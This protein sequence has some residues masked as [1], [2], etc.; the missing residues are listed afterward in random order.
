[1]P[2]AFEEYAKRRLRLVRR[3]LKAFRETG[4]RTGTWRNGRIVDTTA[5]DV[6]EYERQEAELV[7]L[8][9]KQGKSGA[10]RP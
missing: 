6:K 5:E 7:T 8:M 2:D 3:H 9:A 4:L 10:K 1:M